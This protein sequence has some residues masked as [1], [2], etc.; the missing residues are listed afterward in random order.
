MAQDPKAASFTLA[1]VRP[2]GLGMDKGLWLRR[3]WRQKSRRMRTR[4]YRIGSIAKQFTTLMLLQLV[5]E[6]KDSGFSLAT[7]VKKLR[8]DIPTLG[9]L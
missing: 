4:L 2:S 8:Q 5:H 6:G 9:L 3:F 7:G 1:L